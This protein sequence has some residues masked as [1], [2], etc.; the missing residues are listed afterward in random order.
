MFNMDL[1]SPNSETCLNIVLT[2]CL[3][4]RISSLQRTYVFL[5]KPKIILKENVAKESSSPAFSSS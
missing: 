1:T 2:S 4:W 3:V 5:I